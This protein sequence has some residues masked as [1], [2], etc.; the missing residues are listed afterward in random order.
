MF[1]VGTQI[2]HATGEE[3]RSSYLGNPSGNAVGVV[4]G[5][6]PR[7]IWYFG[8]NPIVPDEHY[9]PQRNAINTARGDFFYQWSFAPIRSAA[10][11][12][13]TAVNT[14][15]GASLAYS[16]GGPVTAAFYY[17]LYAT[18]MGTPQYLELGLHPDVEVGE[19]GLLSLT[20]APE[21]YV[22][23]GVVD[24]DALGH[25]ATMEVPFTVDVEDPQIL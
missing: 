3:P 21:Y 11:T 16:E 23:N 22:H 9:L 2:T 17:P 5:D 12:R 14:T 7:Q 13:F 10:A 6:N 25:G 18:W 15:T 20:L 8:G 19:S 1:D 24:W 4:Y